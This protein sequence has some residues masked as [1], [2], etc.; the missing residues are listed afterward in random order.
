MRPCYVGSG[1]IHKRWS[2][3]LTCGPVMPIMD[4]KWLPDVDASNCLKKEKCDDQ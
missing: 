2:C 4:E 1:T 3:D